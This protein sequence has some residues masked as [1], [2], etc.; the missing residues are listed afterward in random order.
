MSRNPK[1][2]GREPLDQYDYF[3]TEYIEETGPDYM[4]PIGSFILGFSALEHALNLQVAELIN[5]RA[6][7]PGY[8]VMEMLSMRNKID[9]FSRMLRP[10]FSSGKDA[11]PERLSDLVSRLGSLNTFRNRIVH[12]NW[13]SLRNDNTVRT[14]IVVE[15]SEGNVLFERMKVTPAI[16]E[17]KVE[18]CEKVE[19]ELEGFSESIFQI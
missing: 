16:I 13:M 18:E 19:E 12:A 1:N 14:K 6:H 9:L 17:A 4:E 11:N 8:Q 7:N 2:S 3:D 5:E 15:E 10:Y